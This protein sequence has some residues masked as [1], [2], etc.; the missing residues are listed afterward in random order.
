MGQA[1]ID[2]GCGRDTMAIMGRRSTTWGS[3]AAGALMLSVWC[4]ALAVGAPPAAAHTPNAPTETQSQITHAFSIFARLPSVAAGRASLQGYDVA[5]RLALQGARDHLEAA[6]PTPSRLRV[7]VGR[8]AL[9]SPAEA[10]VPLDI[11]FEKTPASASLHQSFTAVALEAHHVWQVS[12]TTLC[13]LVEVGGTVCPA[14]P[15][16]L[17]AGDV[18]PHATGSSLDPPDLTPGLIDPG[19]LAVAPGGGVLIAD[20]ARNQILEWKSGQLSVIAGNGLAGFSGDGGPATQA[21]LNDP[22]QIAVGP[23]GT[24]YFV[25]GAN[26]RVRA[27]S[28]NGIIRTVAGDGR[29]GNAGD[30]GPA[31]EA[32]LD[33]SG[34]AVGPTGFLWISSGDSIREVDPAGI[35]SS[36]VSGGPPIGQDVTVKGVPTAFE[37]GSLALNGQGNLV[38][39][40]Y[41]PKILFEVTPAHQVDELAQDYATALSTAPNGTVLVA[42]HGPALDQA[43]STALTPLVDFSMVSVPGLLFG[44]L[45]P[46]GVAE[47]ADGTIY[48]DTQPGDGLTDQTGLF[49][50]TDG[51]VTALAVTTPL[52]DTLPAV[53]AA[54]FSATT[55]PAA[56]PPLSRR[57][58]LAA[59][60]S[61]QGLEAFSPA[62]VLTARHLVGGWNTS[63]AYDLHASDRA[64]WFGAVTTFTGGP[65]QGRQSIVSVVTATKDLYAS[66]VAHACGAAL[67]RRSLAIVMGPSAYSSAVV[68]L[69]ALDRDGTVLIYFQDY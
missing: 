23:N 46:E 15:K 14:T 48:V 44:P 50:I 35:I 31:T 5:M 10:T 40:S 62:A 59:C 9:A 55:Y 4:L 16:G 43:S 68:H 64:W 20:D 25:D 49:A 29:S 32:A 58:A 27:I 12:W 61:S 69:F 22:G 47:A 38:V 56:Q 11:T 2:I 65:L 51:R 34:V 52:L 13:L 45:A 39:F 33:P 60:P 6:G 41:S 7:R 67:V 18:L 57:S 37:P 8:A 30:G 42:Q 28:L 26:Q 36:I 54:G 17:V 19:A 63:F 24:A 3:G 1:A 53:G 21:E 66:A